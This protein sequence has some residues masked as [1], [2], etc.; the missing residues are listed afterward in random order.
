M[1]QIEQIIDA[2]LAGF[3]LELVEFERAPRGLLRVYIDRPEGAGAVT[4]DDC[5]RVS[6]QL[7]LAFTV[8]GVEYDRLEVSSPGLDRILKSTRDFQRFAGRPVRV[9]LNAM[10]DGRKR[11]DG[12]VVAVDGSQVSF[13]ITESPAT[14][15]VAAKSNAKKR[16]HDKNSDV[17]AP[18]QMHVDLAQIEK[19]RLIPQF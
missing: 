11:F 1:A 3:S 18:T 5:Q 9:R 13:E 15:V 14:P 16:A 8:E 4:V 12:V 10:I 19:A 17:P 2:A 7:T 6:N